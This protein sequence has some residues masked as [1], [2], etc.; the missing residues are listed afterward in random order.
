MKN[1][2]AKDYGLFLADEDP[3]K[4]VWLENGKSLEYYLVRSGD[5]LEYRKKIRTLKVRMLDGSTKTMLVD[6]SQPIGQLMIAV[7][8]RIGITNHDEYSLVRELPPEEEK[9]NT[10]RKD[11]SMSKLGTLTLS[12]SKEKKMELL[13]K[14]LHTDEELNWVDHSKTLRE[15]GI[16]ENETV[17]LRRK[18]FFS[19][20][21]ID[22]RDPVQLNLLYVQCRDGILDGTHPVSKEEAF[23]FAGYQCQI[24]F[25][26][27]EKM[28]GKNK[29]APRLLGI[30]K[31]CVMRVDEKTKEVLKIYPL[32]QVR[33]WAASPNTFTLDFGDYQDAYYSVQTTEG[34]K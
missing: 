20:R 21:N 4:G 28:K 7:C 17:L 24:Q 10:L 12:R 3:T 1:I 29:L 6:D 32:E 15:Q 9:V 11:D 25:G 31:D 14:Q 2:P 16:D 5:L 22:A 19:D 26:D 27:F 18:Y 33:R 13:R 8:S 30:N 34:E 23:V